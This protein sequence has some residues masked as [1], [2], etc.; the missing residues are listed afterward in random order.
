MKNWIRRTLLG[1]F[2]A[3]IVLGGLTACGHSREH[4]GWGASAQ[5]QERQR[6]KIVARVAQRLELGEAQK[7]K[8]R[9]LAA[10]VQAQRAAL[11]AQGDPRT[12]LRSLVAGEKLDRAQALALARTTAGAIETRSPA[13]VNA[14]ADFY[15][16]LD[17]RQ[18]ALVR[19]HM[20]GRR[21]WWHRG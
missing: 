4:R 16:S 15:D 2:G 3:S 1:V 13:V 12:Q 10:T 5:E 11:Q 17:A 20:Q 7:E 18:Q 6:E 9:A 19:E 8:L 14:L 21:G